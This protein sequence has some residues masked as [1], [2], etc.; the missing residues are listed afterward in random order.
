S[1]GFEGTDCTSP[2]CP[3]FSDRRNGKVNLMLL[4]ASSDPSPLV[5]TA[6][7]MAGVL[8]GYVMLVRPDEW[9]TAWE[10]IRTSWSKRDRN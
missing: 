2:H 3:T 9:Q 1:G 8:V 10:T 7:Y 4:I 6:V 5:Q